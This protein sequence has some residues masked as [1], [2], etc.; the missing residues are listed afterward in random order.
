MESFVARHRLKVKGILTGFDRIRF[1]GTLCWPANVRGLGAFLWGTKVLLKGFKDYAMGLSE[2]ANRRYLEPLADEDAR[3]F[4]AVAP[5]PSHSRP[6]ET[7]IR[8]NSPNQ[9]HNNPR[10]MRKNETL[11]V[12]MDLV[13]T[14][15][16]PC[17]R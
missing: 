16:C 12:R 9:Q 11:V 2:A 5:K 13:P 1:R 7:P 17:H 6:H 10:N 14:R 8:R 4:Q 3:L 15:L